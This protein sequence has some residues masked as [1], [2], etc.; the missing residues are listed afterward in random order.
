[1]I[2]GEYLGEVVS[3]GEYEVRASG[4]TVAD[5]KAAI[6]AL[7]KE[8]FL[9]SF[10]ICYN[11]TWLDG[12]RLDINNIDSRVYVHTDST[13]AQD[14]VRLVY[15]YNGDIVFREK[16][17]SNGT[18]NLIERKVSNGTYEVN[19][20][21]LYVRKAVLAI[22]GEGNI[23]HIIA[24]VQKT[25][26][27]I[28]AYSK[29]DQF[30]YNDDLYKATTSIALGGTI[31]IGTNAV[32]ANSITEQMGI[33]KT[34][35]TLSAS[36]IQY[37][38]ITNATDYGSGFKTF[39]YKIGTRVTINIALLNVASNRWVDV[40]T[41]PTGFRPYYNIISRASCGSGSPNGCQVRIASSGEVS[42]YVTNS[43][44]SNYC[45]GIV[46]FDTFL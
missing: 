44:S 30:V 7:S 1:M 3:N 35:N 36:I 45:F 42:I 38:T 9:D 32:R 15:Y 12:K 22:P 16:T 11:A 8:E 41:L 34:F 40:F 20:W 17:I 24:P 33:N 14:L 19:R 43:S 46:E 39:Y 10:L 13:V 6:N 4:T 18:M 23:A 21:E 37:P 27:A 5:L 26:T 28:K 31:T 29:D 25:L 2:F